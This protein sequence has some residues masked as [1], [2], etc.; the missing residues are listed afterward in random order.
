MLGLIAEREFLSD[1]WFRG[2]HTLGGISAVQGRSSGKT[3]TAVEDAGPMACRGLSRDRSAHSGGVFYIEV[4]AAVPHAILSE[5]FSDVY[6]AS[7]G[8]YSVLPVEGVHAAQ[9]RRKGG[10]CSEP[11]V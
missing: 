2:S 1:L 3:R 6:R 4:R 9:A 10:A 7:V 11:G 5:S 8:A